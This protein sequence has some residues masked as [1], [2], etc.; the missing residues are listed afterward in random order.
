[1]TG[2]ETTVIDWI[3]RHAPDGYKASHQTPTGAD[4]RLVTIERTGGTRDHI[5]QTATISAQVWSPNR[6]EAERT[7]DRIADILLDMW[8]IPQIADI[9]IQSITHNP[10]P[11]P[12]YRERYQ[13]TATITATTA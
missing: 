3:N 10:N 1:M 7:A 5:T 2:I 9:D 4:G 12:P 11:G 13:I 6:K 8:A